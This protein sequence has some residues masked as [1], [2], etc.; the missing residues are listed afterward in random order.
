VA[1]TLVYVLTR[2]AVVS[3]KSGKRLW[4]SHQPPKTHL[5]RRSCRVIYKADAGLV[6]RNIQS[7]KMVHA[8]LLLLMTL[9]PRFISLKRSTQNLQLST[10]WPADYPVGSKTDVGCAARLWRYSIEL[11][12]LQ[13]CAKRS[14]SSSCV[15]KEVTSRARIWSGPR[16]RLVLVR[17]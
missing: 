8:A 14:I 9:G 3:E 2:W 5:S 1:S 7:S 4:Q 13:R 17:P 15:A 6:D 12:A 11:S 16:L 10:S